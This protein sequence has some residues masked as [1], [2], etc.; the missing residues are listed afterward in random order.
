MKQET[1]RILLTIAATKGAKVKHLDIKSA[2]LNGEIKDEIYMQQPEGYVKKGKQDYVLKLKKSIYG[3]KQ[4]ARAWNKK[5]NELLTSKGYTRGKADPCLYSKRDKD[6]WVYILIHVDDILVCSD[7]D[8]NVQQGHI[9][10]KY[11]PTDKME[12]DIMTKPLSNAKHQEITTIIG[13][14][15]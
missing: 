11:C 2:F 8:I 15:A 4:S 9:V 6:S 7:S 12:A 10:M 13:L 1:I 14:S 5:I 3:L